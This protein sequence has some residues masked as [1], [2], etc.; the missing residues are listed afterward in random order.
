MPRRPQHLDHILAK[1]PF[2]PG[3]VSVREVIGFDGRH[4]LQLRVDMGVLQMEVV[5]RPDGTKPGGFDTYF[6][7]LLA[8]SFEEG[9]EFKF[10]AAIC[11]EVDREFYQFYHRRICW[12]TLHKYAEAIRDAEHTL[13][14]MDFCSAFSPEPQW[15]ML[16]EQYRPFVLF[17]KIQAQ[18]L[19]RLEKSTPQAAVEVLDGGLEELKQI[20]RQH[21]TEDDF[22]ND[23]FA[24]KLL[25]MRVSILEQ[26]ALGPTLAEQLAD[27]IAAEQYELAAA[28]RDRMNQGS[29]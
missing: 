28:L 8:Q 2:A 25:E 3:Q 9:T 10:D 24:K 1:W 21:E 17:H 16:H 29:R 18:V 19:E 22:E 13:S 4:L 12:L 11:A 27:A 15:T 23:E 14:F 5:G 6:D 20:Y 7:Y 26:Y